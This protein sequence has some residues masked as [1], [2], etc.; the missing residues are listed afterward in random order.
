M[1][2]LLALCL[3][4][5]LLAL[6]QAARAAGEDT[7]VSIIQVFPPAQTDTSAPVRIIV[8]A[9][10]R[11]TH[12]PLAGRTAADFA[13]TEDNNPVTPT[14]QIGADKLYAAILLDVSS[15]M[16]SP[17]VLGQPATG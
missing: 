10:D 8:A 6:P 13:V 4:V 9:Q 5:A 2:R 3:A 7:T 15:S 17:I 14:V 16:K 12:A 1:K 11:A